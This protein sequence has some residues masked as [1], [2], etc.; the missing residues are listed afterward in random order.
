MAE[1]GVDD[2]SA[3][4]VL[5]AHQVPVGVPGLDRRRVAE[6][7]LEHLDPLTAWICAEAK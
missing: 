6:R 2:G 7:D 4:G 1:Q 5:V 3:A